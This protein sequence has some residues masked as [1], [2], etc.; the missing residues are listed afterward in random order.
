M[1]VVRRGDVRQ[2]RETGVAVPVPANE[3]A[4]ATAVSSR[5]DSS[6][7][8]PDGR[9]LVVVDDENTAVIVGVSSRTFMPLAHP[10][11]VWR[12]TADCRLVAT[13]RCPLRP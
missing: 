4:A 1:I 6:A 2:N 13:R 3:R 12:A 7:A 11:G 5:A 8:A 9:R 10:G